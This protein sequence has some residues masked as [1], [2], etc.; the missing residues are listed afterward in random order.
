MSEKIKSTNGHFIFLQLLERGRN[1]EG[2]ELDGFQTKE[3]RDHIIDFCSDQT[4][5]IKKLEKEKQDLIQKYQEPI[6]NSES[7]YL[8]SLREKGL[9]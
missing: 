5:L 4:N 7:K 9:I 1:G 8:N 6:E 2:I 3:L